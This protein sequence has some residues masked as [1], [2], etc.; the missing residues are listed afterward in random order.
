M[1]ATL[2]ASR[3]STECRQAFEPYDLQF[4]LFLFA[5]SYPSSIVWSLVHPCHRTSQPGGVIRLAVLMA[6]T[7]TE[8]QCHK[9]LMH[10]QVDSRFPVTPQ[11][12]DLHAVGA[13]SVVTRRVFA[14][15]RRDA[16]PRFSSVTP[17]PDNNTVA[18][19]GR[20]IVVNCM[21][22][23]QHS[24]FFALWSSS[25]IHC[26]SY[27][28]MTR[29]AAAYVR[30][31]SLVGNIHSIGFSQAGGSTSVTSTTYSGSGSCPCFACGGQ[32][33]TGPHARSTPRRSSPCD[34]AAPKRP[35]FGRLCAYC[36]S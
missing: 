17:T 3:H 34:R 11:T 23:I 25:P 32:I 28:S 27:H 36:F 26:F 13:R 24:V 6:F 1:S 21:S 30:T 7:R 35:R 33:S 19:S 14:S 16:S 22:S 9:E 31:H 8:G 18:G 2:Y 29:Y 20:D 10:S 5:A 15:S 12:G 4:L